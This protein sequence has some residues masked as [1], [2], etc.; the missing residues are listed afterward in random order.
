MGSEVQLER[1]IHGYNAMREL[2]DDVSSGAWNYYDRQFQGTAVEL[3]S[4]YDKDV[5][6]QKMLEH[7]AVFRRQVSELHR[8]YRTQRDLMEEMRRS[9]LYNQHKPLLSSN[10]VVYQRQDSGKWHASVFPTSNSACTSPSVLGAEHS[11]PNLSLLKGKTLPKTDVFSAQDADDSNDCEIIECRPGKVRRKMFDLQLSAD[12]YIDPDEVHQ[13]ASV[14]TPALPFQ[15]SN[16]FRSVQPC[17]GVNGFIGDFVNN[18]AKGSDWGRSGG[19]GKGY[20]SGRGGSDMNDLNEP[21]QIED[22]PPTLD[23]MNHRTESLAL[24]TPPKTYSRENSFA[25]RYG[26]EYGQSGKP[27][28]ADR[29]NNKAKLPHPLNLGQFG[30]NESSLSRYL[31]PENYQEPP[32]R[33]LHGRNGASYGDSFP[34]LPDQTKENFWKD[35]MMPGSKSVKGGHELFL[36]PQISSMTISHPSEE[37]VN[38]W[39]RRIPSREKY[40]G[41]KRPYFFSSG[42]LSK[43]SQASNRPPKV[44]GEKVDINSGYAVDVPRLIDLDHGSSSGSK[45]ESICYPSVKFKNLGS[46]RDFAGASGCS[47]NLT[48]HKFSMGLTGIDLNCAEEMDLNATAAEDAVHETAFAQKLIADDGMG[49]SHHTTALPWLNPK[50]FGS[51]TAQASFSR[52]S[53]NP[54]VSKIEG[55]ESAS[56]AFASDHCRKKTNGFPVLSQPL[57]AGS[58]RLSKGQKSEMKQNVRVFDMNLPCETVTNLEAPAAVKTADTKVTGLKNCF[59][60][61]SCITEEEVSMNSCYSAAKNGRGIDLEA[62]A[63][64][65]NEEDMNMIRGGEHPLAV[66]EAELE[67]VAAEAMI[68][69]CSF[70]E[71]EI[72]ER[73]ACSSLNAAATEALKWF[74]GVVSSGPE[75]TL[76]ADPQPNEEPIMR[77]SSDEIDYF[78]HMTIKL[79]EMSAEDY[80]PKSAFIPIPSMSEEPVSAFISSRPRRGQARRGRPKRDFQRDI[81]PGLASLSRHEVT[82][83]I[84]AFDGVMKAGGHAWQFG[85]RAAA[86]ARNKPRRGRPRTVNVAPAPPPIPKQPPPS[87]MDDR[88]LT[89]WGKNTRRPRR[90]RCPAGHLQPVRFI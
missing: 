7:D 85:K 4:E 82:E 50:P 59:D 69:F 27:L 6:K 23:F 35:R 40:V 73:A 10:P 2:G 24:Q 66:E 43:S 45:E 3:Y 37:L 76:N 71:D 34:V 16:G 11:S 63:P 1:Y 30:A 72:L 77:A 56:R 83:D 74:V 46:G 51:D 8:L 28:L 81:L 60:L 67:R 33:L 13:N 62:P 89:G 9:E 57:T 61:N 86:A 20:G 64:V 18:A 17:F 19:S 75:Q 26:G 47:G 29:E 55:T 44:Y 78:E 68:S 90:Q 79:T 58:F 70:K 32:P 48:S 14:K 25:S 5:L 38:S 39:P 22:D 36:G 21:I 15:S 41:E 53:F 54:L 42:G 87:C 80:F 52:A 88:N 65:E 84:Q 12:E 49:K 31:R